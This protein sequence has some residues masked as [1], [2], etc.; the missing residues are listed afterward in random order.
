MIVIKSVIRWIVKYFFLTACAILILVYLRWFWL[1]PLQFAQHEFPEVIGIILLLCYA[2][3]ATI[4]KITQGRFPS[5]L[6]LS[7]AALLTLALNGLFIFYNMPLLITSIDC[8]GTTYS[9]ISHVTFLES[10]GW[11]YYELTTWKGTL[12]KSSNLGYGFYHDNSKLTCDKSTN[13]VR[14]FTGYSNSLAKSYGAQNYTY[15]WQAEVS[16]RNIDYVL[17]SYDI[18]DIQHFL[19]TAC[20]PESLDSCEYIPIDQSVIPA[21]I[22]SPCG[23]QYKYLDQSG[24]LIVDQG[25]GDIYILIDGKIYADL[26][27]KS[28]KINTI[29]TRD[30]NFNI[31]RGTTDPVSYYGLAAYQANHSFIYVL[32]VCNNKTDECDY[33]P[34]SYTTVD[35]ENV[36]LDIDQTNQLNV[37]IGGKLIFTYGPPSDH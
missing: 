20:R 34:F 3:F 27:N 29:A 10:S 22:P 24:N 33:I 17:Y 15:D 9:V 28:R 11:D 2:F 23:C 6:L 16:L 14:L 13:D 32:Y 5:R 4:A 37:H 19:V 1:A 36:S 7:F 18:N 26:L 31:P 21:P 12:Y 8:N 25:T 30:V 35:Q